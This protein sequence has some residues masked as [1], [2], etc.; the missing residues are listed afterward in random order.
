LAIAVGA[1][2]HIFERL[3][4]SSSDADRSMELRRWA[5]YPTEAIE[6]ALGRSFEATLTLSDGPL[7]APRRL[8]LPLRW[9]IEVW[10]P[11]LHIHNK[12]AVVATSRQVI[13]GEAVV[14]ADV[15]RPDGTW[16]RRE[17]VQVGL[18]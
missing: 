15:V 1:T 18:R 5:H 12:G 3:A 14:L 8:G 13:S 11:S 10:A 4:S 7:L 17:T 9:L 16:W 2:R 6:D